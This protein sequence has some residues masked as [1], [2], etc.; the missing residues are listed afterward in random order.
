MADS[1]K[2]WGGRFSEDADETF[3]AFNRSI[4]FDKKLFRHD[5]LASIAHCNGLQ[6]AGL[7]SEGEADQI[8]SALSSMIDADVEK[9]I[10]QQSGL[11]EDVHSLIESNLIAMIGDVG[12]KA[13]TGRSRNDQVATA[14]RLWM[15]DAVDDSIGR[16]IKFMEGLTECAEVNIDV[17]IPGYT[18]LQKAQPILFS[19]WCLAYFEMLRR[20]LERLSHVRRQVNVMPLG[21][22]ALAGSGFPIDRQSV[23]EELGFE[24]ITRNSLDGVSDRDFTLDFA[25]AASILM[26]HLSRFAEDLIIYSSDEFGFVELGDRISTGSSLM[27]QKKNPDAMELLRGKSARVFGGNISLLT[28]MKGLPLAYNKDMQEDKEAVFDIV[29]TVKSS[30]DIAAVIICNIS[31]N[32]RRCS[33]SMGTGFMNATDLAD[34]MVGKGLPFRSAHEIVGAMVSKSIELNC[35]LEELPL[36][37]VKSFSSLIEDDFRKRISL[38]RVLASKVVIGGTSRDRV[39]SELADAKTFLATCNA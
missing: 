25:G 33:D 22:G 8:R 17:V 39:A 38:E 37:V 21:S 28:L 29:E 31:L 36:E 34:Y 12:R 9:L 20:D 23:A 19:H 26:M 4:H 7:L 1:T 13:H 27:P 11:P 18:H 10:A 15:K 35:R 5:V 24:S 30:L 6:S 2:L 32:R 14:F 3:A 16:A